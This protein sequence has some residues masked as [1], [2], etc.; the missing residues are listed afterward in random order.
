MSD[1]LQQFRDALIGRGIVPPADLLADGIIHRCDAEGRGGKNDA[2]YLLHLDGISAGGFENW[3]DG[4]GWENWRADVGRTLTPTEEAAHRAQVEVARR[5]REA[6]EAK[7][8][9]EARETARLKWTDD[10]IRG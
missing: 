5:E 1:A 6:E 10:K 3:R 8:K 7:R 9:E 2:A 4:L